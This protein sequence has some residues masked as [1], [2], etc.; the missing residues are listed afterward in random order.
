MGQPVIHFEIGCR[1][2]ANTESFYTKLFGWQ[3]RPAGPGVTIDTEGAGGING[4]FT[5]LGHEPHHYVTIY[6][7][8][9]DLQAYLSKAERLG[10]KTLIP[11]IELP[12]GRHFAWLA[13]P[14]GNMIGLLTPTG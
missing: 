12:D 10:G 2:I 13:D 8:V 3:T 5:S 7:Q 4:H 1:D 9:D 11:P 14:D 6:I